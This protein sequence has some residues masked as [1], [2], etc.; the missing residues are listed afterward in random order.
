[1]TQTAMRVPLRLKKM[2]GSPDAAVRMDD[3]CICVTAGDET[4]LEALRELIG[5]FVSLTWCGMLFL[6]TLC[7]SLCISNY[8]G[9]AHFNLGNGLFVIEGSSC[10]VNPSL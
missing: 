5:N 1:M 8:K 7:S 2:E 4:I 3:E 6:I 9:I 10:S